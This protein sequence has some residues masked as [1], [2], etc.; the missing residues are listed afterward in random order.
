[1][2]ALLLPFYVFCG[3]IGSVEKNCFD[4][5]VLIITLIII[6]VDVSFIYYKYVNFEANSHTY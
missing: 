6:F 3:F 2:V 1:M 5:A 4:I